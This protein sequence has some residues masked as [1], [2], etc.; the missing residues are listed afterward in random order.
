MNL[1]S[2]TKTSGLPP[3]TARQR[4]DGSRLS[5]IQGYLPPLRFTVAVACHAST[6]SAIRP[7]TEAK[8]CP[9]VLWSGPGQRRQ[10]LAC[11]H[12]M[13]GKPIIKGTVEPTESVEH[14]T[15]REP[16][17]ESEI[18]NATVSE[19]LGS[20][21]VFQP[22]QT[23]HTVWCEADFQISQRQLGPCWITI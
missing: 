14:A 13:A 6:K 12:L 4:T 16:E 8:A 18:P 2:Q 20:F 11:L 1:G 9:V 23:W 15:L 5:L 17:E 19:R 10:I 22:H 3:N 7:T 21:K